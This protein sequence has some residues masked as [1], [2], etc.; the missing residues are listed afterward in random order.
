MKTQIATL[1]LVAAAV[2]CTPR[3]SVADAPAETNAP[4]EADAPAEAT[5]PVVDGAVVTEDAGGLPGS[6]Q[7]DPME[8]LAKATNAGGLL[9]IPLGLAGEIVD[10]YTVTLAQYPGSAELVTDLK[11]L[12]SELGAETVDG[13]AVGRLLRSLGERTRAVSEDAGNYAILGKAL[14]SAGEELAGR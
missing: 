4:A 9:Q 13:A 12:R 3:A 11:S 6:P 1:F 7:F 5:S 10:D 2:A 8:V 14:E